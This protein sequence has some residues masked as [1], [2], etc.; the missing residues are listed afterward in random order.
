MLAS[1]MMVGKGAGHQL[2]S[3]AARP[4]PPICHWT[5][6]PSGNI[7]PARANWPSGVVRNGAARRQARR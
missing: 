7:G 1:M 5:I 3:I 4:P 6:L 2:T